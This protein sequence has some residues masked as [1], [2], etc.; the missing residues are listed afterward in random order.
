MRTSEAHF[1]NDNVVHDAIL[2]T[3]VTLVSRD[4]AQ[5]DEVSRSFQKIKQLRCAISSPRI[6]YRHRGRPLAKPEIMIVDECLRTP[7]F[8][9]RLDWK[10]TS[11]TVRR[12]L[13]FHLECVLLGTKSILPDSAP[14]LCLLVIVFIDQDV[15][16]LPKTNR[17]RNS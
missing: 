5:G 2:E 3:D 16:Q 12:S 1:S 13:R 15:T 10:G 6:S 14:R 7:P 17:A 11:H 9:A 4:D 8:L